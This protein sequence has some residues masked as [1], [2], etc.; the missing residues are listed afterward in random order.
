LSL[1]STFGENYL[2]YVNSFR[3]DFIDGFRLYNFIDDKVLIEYG[4][5]K[6]DHRQK[7]LDAIQ[8]LRKAFLNERTGIS[9]IKINNY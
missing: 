5:K 1:G 8:Q 6:E 7:I 2:T 4:V 3:K 9:I